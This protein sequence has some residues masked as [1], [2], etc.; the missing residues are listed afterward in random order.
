MKTIGRVLTLVA[1]F[2]AAAHAALPEGF[3]SFRSR[4]YTVV[5][6]VETERVRPI[7]LHMDKVFDEYLRR[8]S[9]AGFRQR[10]GDQ[11]TLYVFDTQQT[12]LTE[13]AVR[14]VNA[15]GS[16]GMFFVRD[17]ES[18]LAT[19]VN[20]RDYDGMIATLQHE[21]FHQFAWIRIG[22]NLPTWANEGLAEY[23]GDALLVKGKFAIGQVDDR[24]V[25]RLRQAIADGQTFG[26]AELLNM[27]GEQWIARVNQADGR[28]GLMYDQSWSIVHF[29]VHGNNGRF[30]P[31]FMAYLLEI[32]KGRSSEQAFEKAFGSTDYTPFEKAW[33]Q[34]V[35][36]L[37]PDPLTTAN[38]RLTFMAGG[39][40]YL[41]DENVAVD[42][43]EQLRS[44]LQ[45]RGY[46]LRLSAHGYERKVS[47]D[48]ASNFE[49]PA[50]DR[51][52][53]QVTMVLEPNKDDALPPTVVVR[54]LQVTPR[55]EW[56]LGPEGKPAYRIVYE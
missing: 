3:S 5:T 43:I 28:A 36:E 9:R 17:G 39:L 41:H 14:G 10:A 45:K 56:S 8:L 51:P 19:F 20:G 37:Q 26:F 40:R 54:G 11:M 34:Y 53:R 44:E 24:R 4:R 35:A 38:E 55:I 6:N 49:P 25:Q 18:G 47:A 52:G 22:P 21:G 48:D 42:S 16:G 31:A 13:L 2:A 29:L 23:F 46:W 33:K 1:A 12:Y 50:P 30:Q 7:A 32:H 15:S 27:T